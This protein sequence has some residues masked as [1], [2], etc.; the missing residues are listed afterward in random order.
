LWEHLLLAN[1]LQAKMAWKIPSDTNTKYLVS[2]TLF[3]KQGEL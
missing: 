3:E 2:F 1:H